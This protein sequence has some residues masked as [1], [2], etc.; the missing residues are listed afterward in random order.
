MKETGLKAETYVQPNTLTNNEGEEINMP[1]SREGQAKLDAKA[2]NIK[3]IDDVPMTPREIM[4]GI[5][6]SSY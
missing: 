5:G 2:G 1:C 4:D 6:G 3:N